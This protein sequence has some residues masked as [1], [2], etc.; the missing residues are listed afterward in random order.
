MA[1]SWVSFADRVVPV[2]QAKVHQVRRAPSS[3]SMTLAGLTSRCTT[4]CCVGVGQGLGQVADN[5]GRLTE[6]EPARR[7]WPSQR[8]ARDKGRGD[9][10][11]VAG[12]AGLV[13]GDDVRMVQLARRPGF[14]QEA[15][16]LLGAVQQAGAGH[17]EG[18]L[19]VQLRIVRPVDRAERAAAQLAADLKAADG[20]RLASGGSR[21]GRRGGSPA[22]NRKDAFVGGQRVFVGRGTRVRGSSRAGADSFAGGGEDE[23]A[24]RSACS[25]RRGR[26]SS[27]GHSTDASTVGAL[28]LDGHGRLPSQRMRGDSCCCW[29]GE[30]RAARPG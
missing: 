24:C 25:G 23:L 2:G 11:V 12:L 5:L 7:R 20:E 13:D 8:L 27:R 29:P 15:L 1:P 6:V 3:S 22:R 14:A 18:D 30:G 28:H 19:A 10:I 9:V 16:D 21:G 26:G 4:P 17:L